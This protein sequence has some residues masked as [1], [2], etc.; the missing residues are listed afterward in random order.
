M[1]DQGGTLLFS[2]TLEVS[3]YKKDG[4]N[5][6]KCK[7]K[8]GRERRWFLSGPD[9]CLLTVISC[10]RWTWCVK[11][12][13][14]WGPSKSG[15]QPRG[16]HLGKLCAFCRDFRKLVCCFAVRIGGVLRTT[17][18]RYCFDVSNELLVYVSSEA[19]L[20]QGSN[21]EHCSCPLLWHDEIW[22]EGCQVLTRVSNGSYGLNRPL[23]VATKFVLT[24]TAS[25]QTLI[26]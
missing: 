6:Q 25:K 5:W 21:Q 1:R 22:G 10:W 15:D 8:S 2:N 4:W 12:A 13:G 24:N 3:D 16:H 14:S 11:I 17:F 7:D 20:H 9:T 18:M 23:P 26:G 19:V